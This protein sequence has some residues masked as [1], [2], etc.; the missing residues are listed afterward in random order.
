MH[1]ERA[2]KHIGLNVYFN[3]GSNVTP[4]VF[5][6]ERVTLLVVAAVAVAVAVV[7]PRARA[8]ARAGAGAGAGAGRPGTATDAATLRRRRLGGVRSPTSPSLL[9][10][11]LRFRLA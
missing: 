8:R 5:A 2:S 1:L 4:S 10:D 7:R 11:R 3:P 6:L 9:A